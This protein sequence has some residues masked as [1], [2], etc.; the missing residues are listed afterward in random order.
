M[1]SFVLTLLA[2]G[3]LSSCVV[4]RFPAEIKVHVDLPENISEEQVDRLID[5][6]PPTVGQR[7]VK[8]RLEICSKE[9]TIKEEKTEGKLPKETISRKKSPP[10]YWKALHWFSTNLLHKKVQA[11][12]HCFPSRVIFS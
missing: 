7:N 3:L 9:G 10:S 6:I 5:K 12:Q 4:V 8:T 1:K 2:A 11:T